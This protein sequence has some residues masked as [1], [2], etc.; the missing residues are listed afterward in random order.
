MHINQ[1]V[2]L[3]FVIIGVMKISKEFFVFTYRKI[4]LFFCGGDLEPGTSETSIFHF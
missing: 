1:Y 2:Y 4:S 3:Q